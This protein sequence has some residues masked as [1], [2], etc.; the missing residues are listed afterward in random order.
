[1]EQAKVMTINDILNSTN[2]PCLYT[3]AA[4]DGAIADVVMRLNTSRPGAAVRVVRG[5]KSRTV[6]R[7]FDEVSAALQF[8]YYFGENWDAFDE[9]IADLDWLPAEA[10]LLV[11]T[12]ADL[13]LVDE[14]DEKLRI[15]IDTLSL[16]RDEWLTPNQY[17]PRQR[18]QT[19]FHVVLQCNDE[20][21][22]AK[23]SA[24]LSRV[25]AT[26]ERLHDAGQ[27]P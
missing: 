19:P 25:H 15:L 18:P 26:F 9:M 21:A 22:L 17:I 11:F 10:Y 1:V 2:P 24:R 4:T 23:L 6:E 20:L 14:D 7:F 16:A 8:P 5:R 27:S 3:L 12:E 13:T